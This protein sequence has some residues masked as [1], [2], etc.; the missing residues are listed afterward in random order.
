MT[1]A[2]PG[3]FTDALDATVEPGVVEVDGVPIHYRAWGEP[4]DASGVVLVHG[5]AAHSRWWDHI[6]PFLAGNRR[7]V[8]ASVAWASHATV[9][10]PIVSPRLTPRRAISSASRP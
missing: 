6:A 4:S 2:A 1:E 3:W 5:G 7:V 10:A 9:S 8:A